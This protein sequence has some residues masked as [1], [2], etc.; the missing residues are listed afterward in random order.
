ME[1]IVSAGGDELYN[2]IQVNTQSGFS[3]TVPDYTNVTGG[4]GVFSSRINLQRDAMLSSG[5]KRDLYGK[6]AWGFIEH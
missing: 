1:I 5:A 6:R 2:Y 4:F 3:Q